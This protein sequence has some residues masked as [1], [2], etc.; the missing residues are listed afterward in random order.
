MLRLLWFTGGII[1]LTLGTIGVFLPVL[2]TTPFVLL[3]AACFAKSSNRFHDYLMNNK[4]FGPIIKNWQENR[5]MPPKAKIIM[6]ISII[7]SMSYLVIKF[8]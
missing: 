5:T 3:A 6:S 4:H 2:P 1:S 7:I 8:S